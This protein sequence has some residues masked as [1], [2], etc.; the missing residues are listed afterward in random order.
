MGTKTFDGRGQGRGGIAQFTFGK[1]DL[2]WQ[3]KRNE[4]LRAIIDTGEYVF[5]GGRLCLKSPEYFGIQHGNITVRVSLKEELPNYCVAR[6]VPER[7]RTEHRVM[8]PRG[9]VRRGK[10]NYLRSRK[11][12][13]YIHALKHQS[14]SSIDMKTFLDFSSGDG[15]PP[16]GT[17]G[18]GVK[19]Y[20]KREGITQAILAERIGVATDTVGRICRDTNVTPINMAVAVCIGL[21]LLPFESR[22]LLMRLGYTLDGSSP[23]IRA[24][25]L[26]IDV[27][28]NEEVCDCNTFLIEKGL[29]PLT[30]ETE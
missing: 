11:P 18:Q 27:F 30:K 28:Y 14:L 29:K 22:K 10:L 17:F 20:I 5:I 19:F 12:V 3:Y 7:R 9:V 8:P 24:Y 1:H 23:T 16:N 6:I 26:L 4:S 15:E 13:H 2:F 21:H 25:Q